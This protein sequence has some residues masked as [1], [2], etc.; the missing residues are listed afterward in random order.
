M[1]VL[2]LASLARRTLADPRHASLLVAGAQPDVTARGLKMVDRQGIPTF[3]CAP[4]SAVAQ[5]AADGRGAT[6]ILGA[7][8][9]SAT[10]AVSGRLVP[11][12][13]DWLEG[14]PVDVV[15][16]TVVRVTVHHETDDGMAETP[17]PMTDYGHTDDSTIEET[18]AKLVKHLN[19]DH[20]G[21]LIALV[22]R[23]LGRPDGGFAA[24]WLVEL[25]AYGA[26]VHWVDHQGLRTG[27]I[28]FPE[29]AQCQHHLLQLLRRELDAGLLHV[30]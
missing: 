25:D 11:Q 7:H 29:K 4:G 24:A 26:E 13:R 5:A 6:L 27:V 16:L 18:A 15:A 10:V 17:V 22:A 2:N 20:Q 30:G 23:N 14:S 8:A 1:S 9:S 21:D 3:L 28:C 12:G 19:A